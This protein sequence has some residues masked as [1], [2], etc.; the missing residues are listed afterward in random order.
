MHT[1]ITVDLRQ[2]PSELH[3][4]V[5][6]WYRW[7]E[8]TLRGIGRQLGGNPI[9]N[10]TPEY[11]FWHANPPQM[12]DGELILDIGDIKYYLSI[13]PTGVSITKRERNTRT[14][15]AHLQRMDDAKKYLLC[16]MG[17]AAWTTDFAN[18]PS[19]RWYDQGVAAGV[20]LE[21]VNPD[22]EFSDQ[23]LFVADEGD[24]RA[25]MRTMDATWFSHPLLQAYEQVDAKYRESLPSNR[26]T[27]DVVPA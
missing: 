20:H 6:D 15:V 23:F 9:P 14:P 17:D 7:Q 4:L 3:R 11:S 25:T 2:F 22:A 12:A 26:F 10:A 16:V 21:P 19:S 1:Q 18:S 5:L 13:E 27:I 8:A 24:P